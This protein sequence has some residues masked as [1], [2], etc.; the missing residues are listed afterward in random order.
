[1]YHFKIIKDQF[2]ISIRL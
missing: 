1:M 2:M